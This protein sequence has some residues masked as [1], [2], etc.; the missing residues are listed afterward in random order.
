MVAVLKAVKAGVPLF[1]VK[2]VSG[3]NRTVLWLGQ[4]P[5]LRID[6]GCLDKDL[7]P[8]MVLTGFLEGSVVVEIVWMLLH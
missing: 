7:E 4:V 2:L 5:C 6:C 1:G 8:R 3:V